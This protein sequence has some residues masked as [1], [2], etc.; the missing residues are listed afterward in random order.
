[1]LQTWGWGPIVKGSGLKAEIKSIR[2]QVFRRRRIRC[3]AFAVATHLLNTD[4]PPAEHPKPETNKP[5][6]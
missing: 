5:D 2:F 6:Y 1:M 4:P 3:Q